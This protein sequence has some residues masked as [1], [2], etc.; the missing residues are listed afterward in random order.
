MREF[1]GAQLRPA[2]N[3]NSEN[4][5]SARP[6]ASNR[7]VFV[8]KVDTGQECLCLVGWLFG[9]QWRERGNWRI[10]HDSISSSSSSSILYDIVKN[11][12]IQKNSAIRFKK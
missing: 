10:W 4:R 11:N 2:M 1:Y 8:Y 5:F 3:R 6:T 12:F 9:P 7:I